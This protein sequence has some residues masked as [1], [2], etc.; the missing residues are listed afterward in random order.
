MI[1]EFSLF[2]IICR[3]ACGRLDL[4]VVRLSALEPNM[5]LKEGRREKYFLQILY[6]QVH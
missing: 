5:I 4:F 2:L 6:Y 1:K 3:L